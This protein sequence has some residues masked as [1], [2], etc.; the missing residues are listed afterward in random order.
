M[1]VGSRIS[2]FLEELSHLKGEARNTAKFLRDTGR[3]DQLEDVLAKIRHNNGAVD[4][5]DKQFIART[6]E[7]FR[8][9]LNKDDIFKTPSEL[10][11][12]ATARFM[13]LVSP[14]LPSGEARKAFRQHWGEGTLRLHERVPFKERQ[15]A[16]IPHPPK[17]TPAMADL[18]PQA[19]RQI[20]NGLGDFK[21]DE[22]Y[23]FQNV[24]DFA[25][26]WGKFRRV[27]TANDMIDDPK[28]LGRRAFRSGQDVAD[29]LRGGKKISSDELNMLR[30]MHRER[31]NVHLEAV[32]KESVAAANRAQAEA[33]QPQPGMMGGNRAESP[34][35]KK[36]LEVDETNRKFAIDRL[37]AFGD[38]N[39]LFEAGSSQLLVQKFS[40]LDGMMGGF[41]IKQ[42]GDL[43][44]AKLDG[45]G[46]L[47]N[48]DDVLFASMVPVG[49]KPKDGPI[50]ADK[51]VTSS[52]ADPS[53][54]NGKI[55]SYYDNEGNHLT[56]IIGTDRASPEDVNRVLQQL[57]SYKPGVEVHI[58]P[59]DW[60]KVRVAVYDRRFN[61]LSAKISGGRGLDASPGSS[62]L[63]KDSVKTELDDFVET[64]RIT[65]R[66]D[67]DSSNVARRSINNIIADLRGPN[68]KI[69]EADIGAIRDRYTAAR[70]ADNSPASN[71]VRDIIDN[72]KPQTKEVADVQAEMATLRTNVRDAG[73]LDTTPV[74][75][76]EKIRDINEIKAALRNGEQVKTP[77]LEA[78][79]SKQIGDS[80]LSSQ[81]SLVT[82]LQSGF[83][84][85]KRMDTETIFTQLEKI[86]KD[87]DYPLRDANLDAQTRTASPKSI[88]QRLFN[89]E[90]VSDGE[91][92][93]LR[94][95]YKRHFDAGSAPAEAASGGGM[96]IKAL[97]LAQSITDG[98]KD[99][100]SVPSGSISRAAH[101]N[102][103]VVIPSVRRTVMYTALPAAL[104]GAV[105]Q[106]A[107]DPEEPN[108]VGRALIN[109]V[110]P[111]GNKDAADFAEFT[112][113]RMNANTEMARGYFKEYLGTDLPTGSDKN[114]YK[115]AIQKIRDGQFIKEPTTDLR[116]SLMMYASAK[117]TG[118]ASASSAEVQDQ[119][120]KNVD[121]E[122]G[123][124][125]AQI[126]KSAADAANAP[127]I[128][129]E[130]GIGS[131]DYVPPVSQE[132]RSASEFDS[133][134]KSDPVLGLNE[135]QAAKVSEVWKNVAGS[136]NKMDSEEK[137][138]LERNLKTI[139]G[140]DSS[141]INLITA[142]A[143]TPNM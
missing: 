75:D 109:F 130:A 63:G 106:A 62:A 94:S 66:V 37:T 12:E 58:H 23:Q 134:I 124:T 4:L 16:G 57:H 20:A 73:M 40:Q 7:G 91:M 18:T 136:N 69:S 32:D 67:T 11:K 65:G 10:N 24:N 113:G 103:G 84:A 125:E 70:A 82:V 114:F 44:K 120:N 68:G 54:V 26:E 88:N 115:D 142:A 126:A 100:K 93:A 122:R 116:Q 49:V 138:A 13:R 133:Y 141:Q 96:G 98:L 105:G 129:L 135:S 50:P 33:V 1:G 77:E 87:T 31:L 83:N 14:D 52:K 80:L 45:L 107:L 43:S 72:L 79:I 139:P 8:N 102:T 2:N 123:A 112:Y 60:E 55:L 118:V 19:K 22:I 56:P 132:F 90:P 71:S 117:A 92:T 25:T 3:I 76:G 143:F 89:N 81:Q 64:L 21:G 74:V 97:Q 48:S 51:I 28:D 47:Q 61:E 59:A 36:A 35:L 29:A 137:A 27:L 101:Y 111:D 53:D 38:A 99:S 46:N 108:F 104:A 9:S 86:R 140:L 110:Y 5:Q 119:L 6:F 127:P 34:A 121:A 131:P 95:F 15:A 78:Y 42:M 85:N 39:K 17:E 30:D 128:Q 41:S